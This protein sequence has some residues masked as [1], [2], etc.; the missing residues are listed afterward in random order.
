MR[1]LFIRHGDP[2]YVHDSLT[3]LGDREAEELA[4]FLAK[5]DHIDVIYKSPL[6]RAQRTASYT[7]KKL[8]MEGTTYDWLQEIPRGLKI[9]DFSW[10]R[11]AYPDWEQHSDENNV[12]IFW[13]MV[14]RW[15]YQVPGLFDSSKWRESEV[16][17]KSNLLKIYDHVTGEFDKLLASYGYVRENGIYHVERES[18]KTLAFFCHF[19][20]TCV[21]L[22]HLWNTSPFMLWHM[23]GLSPSSV[24][25]C[26]TEEREQGWAYFKSLRIG[27]ISHIKAHN[28]EPAFAGRFCEVYSNKDQR[29]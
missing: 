28:E 21:M 24:T 10:A 7:E 19:G 5:T 22:S 17:K 4:D 16:A 2:D 3:P 29:H 9:D 20:V 23:L 14:P 26:V 27:D 18:T 6:G 12:R 11:E 25:E 8:G 1:L 15:F 13:D